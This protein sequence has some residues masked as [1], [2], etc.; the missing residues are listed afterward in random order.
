MNDPNRLMKWIFVVGLVVLSLIILYPPS[1]KL[2]GG[3]DLVGGSSLLFEIDTA[4]LEATEQRDL[5]SRVMDVLKERVDPDGQLNLEWRPVGNSRLEIRMPRPPKKALERRE[6]YNETIDRLATL[7]LSRFEVESALNA[8]E[9]QR[10][11]SL[12]TLEK[13][14]VE[15]SLLIEEIKAAYT[16]H[17]AAQAGEQPDEAE[18][19]AASY[20]AAMAKLL[21]T[22]LPTSRLTDIL[23]LRV[24][25]KRDKE[26][27]KIRAE[28]PSY[29]KA[30]AD[31]NGG[32]IAQTV[33]AYDEWAKNK[34]DLEDPSDLKRRLK[35]AGVLQFRILADRD[36]SSPENTVH[37]VQPIARYTEQLAKRGPRSKAGDRYQWFPVDDVIRFTYAESMEEFEL[38][39]DLPGRPIVEEYAGRH[40]VLIHQ[41][42]QYGMWQE[43]GKAKKWNLTNVYPDRD[44]MSGENTVNFSLDARG[45]QRFG[46]LTG[47]NVGR[48]L[49]I[50]LDGGAMSQARIN[51]RITTRCRIAGQFTQERVQNLIR[52]LDAG[53]LPARLKETPLSERTIGPSLGESNRQKGV[54]AAGVAMIVV[55]VFVFIYYG[56]MAGGMADVALAMNLLLVLAAMA[57]MQ[58]TF[59]LPGI[60]GLILTV[61]MAIDA[62]VLIFERFR[63]ERDRGLVFKKALNAGYDKAFS[64]IMDANIT[65]L[66]T[67]IILGFVG[68]EEVKGFAIVLGIGITTSMFTSLFVTRLVFNTLIA[69][70]L[71]KDLSMR[72]LIGKPTVAWLDKWRTFV[73]L[74]TVSVL[75]GICLF[76][77]LTSANKEAIFDIEF[78][79]G[80]SL[81]IDLKKGVGMSDDAVKDA[82]TSD[83]PGSSRSWLVRAADQLE[84]SE[85]TAGDLPG[86]FSLSSEELT[87]DQLEVLMRKAMDAKIERGGT[88]ISGRSVKFYGKAGQLDQESFGEALANAVR[89]SREAAGRLRGARVQ[90]VGDI[91][92]EGVKGPSFEVVTIETNRALVQASLLATF[93]DKLDIQS[94]IN[95]TTR[96]DDELTREPFFVVESED[97]YLSD[98]L[99]GDET[100]DIR[101]FR[102]GVAI[103][104]VLEESKAPLSLKEFDKRLREV[105]LQHEFEKFRTL[106]SAI[107]PLGAASTGDE[108]ESMYKRFAVL[109]VDE[110][111]L[112]DDD[113]SMW[114]DVLAKTRLMQIE[115]AL[116]S[117]KSL[118]KV[119]A[120][121]PQIAT[122]TKNRAIFATLLALAAIVSYLWLR[123]GTK[124]YGL[125]AI[126]CLVHDI[127][128]TLGLVALS[129]FV[130]NTAI[131]KAFMISDFKIDLPMIAALLTVIGYSLN[132]TIVVFDRIREN[133]GKVGSLS[134]GL[135]NNSINQT[136]AR[137]V[138]TSITTALV[139]GILYVFGGDGI[140]GFSFALLIG[141][142]VG[143]YSSVAVASALLYKPVI[144]RRLITVIAALC[145]IGVV[146]VE[147]D[148]SAARWVVTGVIVAGAALM[149]MRL[150]TGRSTGSMAQPAGA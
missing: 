114:T 48:Q 81:Q 134:A 123:F 32:L 120:F 21:A 105:G 40:Y 26:L 39:K 115:A 46:E 59:T 84:A 70:G 128:I 141:V 75:A 23:P 136:L 51:E 37:P 138:L 118:S 96:V 31:A 130:F 109:A 65:T 14:I 61:G 67:C 93:G 71:L 13:G 56:F 85:V 5:S 62:N 41:G 132:D 2:K 102:G 33:F 140:H 131:G 77:G 22:S 64:T 55:A 54:Y 74:S 17:I 43:P 133:R 80:T 87:A 28:Y 148:N 129:H 47:N 106:E 90:T 94:P 124:E 107:F 111:I 35:G 92:D 91:E 10:E 42:S 122:Q 143:T 99:G 139:V 25:P 8:E 19:A 117:E 38:Q 116:G 29:D 73:P 127:S 20:E 34:A 36:P 135:I 88:E 12:K 126:V 95:F 1:E 112:Y 144:L 83:D 86:Q 45:G 72:R 98:V 57:L 103:D 9:G 142:V 110:T 76:V 66:I 44:P 18:S 121:A 49:C 108:G 69:K 89:M 82:I 58:A 24:G 150:R 149:L 52:I 119:V 11:A 101:R 146:L 7:N 53:S 4:G 68:S 97:H 79:G 125:A 30:G 104:V 60:A 50:V 147:I 15:R 27:D 145:L 78:L 113:P 63:E 137:T 16:S 100:F 3:I 6:A